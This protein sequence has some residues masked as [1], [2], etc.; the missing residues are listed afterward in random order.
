MGNLLKEKGTAVLEKQNIE[1]KLLHNQQQCE[2]E[3]K[4]QCT[5]YN[6]FHQQ[7]CIK[8]KECTLAHN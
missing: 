2:L 7:F 5:Q 4:V 6:I 3:K 8:F 1:E